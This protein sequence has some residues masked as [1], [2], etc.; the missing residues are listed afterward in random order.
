MAN[1][2]TISISV[3]ADTQEAIDKV[4]KLAN[5]IDKSLKE[6]GKAGTEA[7]KGMKESL[8]NI[9][10][11][12]A[13][14]GLTHMIEK[15][16]EK[17]K[18]F[19]KEAYN[20]AVEDAHIA[21]RFEAIVGSAEEAKDILE[22]IE[23]LKITKF[24]GEGE[25]KH[26]VAQLI[27]AGNTAEAAVAIVER[28]GSLAAITNKP[29][30]SLKNLTDTIVNMQTRG[31]LSVKQLKASFS[32]F[33]INAEEVISKKLGVSILELEKRVSAGAISSEESIGALLE[34]I[35]E[36]FPQGIDKVNDSLFGLERRIKNQTSEAIE[37]LGKAFIK[38]FNFNDNKSITLDIFQYIEEHADDIAE[39]V[40]NIYLKFRE[41]FEYAKDTGSKVWEIMKDGAYLVI[42]AIGTLAIYYYKARIAV[43]EFFGALG[44]KQVIADSLAAIEQLKNGIDKIAKGEL[45]G[46][47]LGEAEKALAA[48]D[49]VLAKLKKEEEIEKKITEERVRSAKHIEGIKATKAD[50]QA[51]KFKEAEDAIYDQIRAI[52]LGADEAQNYKDK[53][54]GI[55]NEYQIGR[56]AV[57]RAMLAE[58]KFTNDNLTGW[59]KIVA[60]VKELAGLVVDANAKGRAFFKTIQG[61]VE[62]ASKGKQK[63]LVD[64]I[65][66]GSEAFIEANARRGDNIE[67]TVK[68][69][70][71]E[72]KAQTKEELRQGEVGNSVLKELQK[73]NNNEGGQDL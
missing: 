43:E 41:W 21:N 12:V 40:H 24:F 47:G 36:K 34:A 31:N 1:V 72:M 27:M 71:E 33:G 60:K 2:S 13:A 5:A 52:Q 62:A 42:D 63:R 35:G 59:E 17:M 73:M 50:T 6:G 48:F 45:F 56:L 54:S 51:A 57:E 58:A 20:S 7:F 10:D 32:E 30:E 68:D 38:A 67:P 22:K 18:D 65:E 70:L 44:D 25:I 55:Y 16:T 28:L 14:I 4:N 46:A 8:K 11:M 61:A 26:D 37:A 29:E 69:I 39:A 49:K 15:A 53:V 3:V 66:A 9:R 23:K 19:V 64:T